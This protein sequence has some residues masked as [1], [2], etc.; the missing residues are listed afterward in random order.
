VILRRFR[1]DFRKNL[2][3]ERVGRHWN[4]LPREVMESLYLEVDVALKAWFSGHGGDGLTAG[5][6]TLSG[7]FRPL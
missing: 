6:D 4:R 3:S 1:L 5:L 7:L 2:F